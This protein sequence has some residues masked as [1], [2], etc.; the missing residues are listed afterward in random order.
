[1]LGEPVIPPVST[2]VNHLSPPGGAHTGVVV[3]AA[4][5]SRE[6]P[7]PESW[8]ETADWVRPA[9]ACEVPG[10]VAGSSSAVEVAVAPPEAVS[11][12]PTIF[13]APVMRALPSALAYCCC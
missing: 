12:P 5:T 9:G 2:P 13:L 3:D 10:G 7:P 11:T 8:L 6:L 4:T 1:M